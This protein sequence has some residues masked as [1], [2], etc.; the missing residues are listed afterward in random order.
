MAS[1]YPFLTCMVREGC[2]QVAL[3]GD[4]LGIA[5]HRKRLTLSKSYLVPI[6]PPGSA[7]VTP[8]AVY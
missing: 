7:T 4:V 6:L 5:L 2:L 3:V 1:V 8:N